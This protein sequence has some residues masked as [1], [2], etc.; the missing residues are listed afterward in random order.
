MNE[1]LKNR[2]FQKK[3][4]LLL[5]NNTRPFPTTIVEMERPEILELVQ[6]YCLYSPHMIPY[7][8]ISQLYLVP[9]QL[10]INPIIDYGDIYYLI[11][12]N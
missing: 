3:L 6:Q 5:G 9:E 11:N 2:F 1:E 7:R 8:V 12:V 10:E 4:Q